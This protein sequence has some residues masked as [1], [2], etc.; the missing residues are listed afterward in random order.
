V[1]PATAPSAVAKRILPMSRFAHSGMANLS[2]AQ[3]VATRA[4][5]FRFWQELASTL[6]SL[7]PVYTELA[8]GTCP[9]GFPAM[10]KDRPLLEAAARKQGVPLSVHWRLDRELGPD[11]ATSHRLSAEMVTLPLCPDITE[12]Q[13]DVL[14]RLLT[15]GW[16]S[17][18]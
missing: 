7:E 1:I 14:A 10:V 13:R 11:C 16:R 12:T 8:P 2:F 17:H 9:L 3:I 15:R 6:D 18:A 4:A 5:S